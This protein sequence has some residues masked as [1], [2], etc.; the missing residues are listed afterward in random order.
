MMLRLLI[1]LLF[2]IAPFAMITVPLFWMI[3]KRRQQIESNKEDD[4]V[5]PHPPQSPTLQQPKV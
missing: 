5:T 3:I 2:I 4:E 1:L